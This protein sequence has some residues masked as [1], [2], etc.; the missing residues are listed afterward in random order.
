[1]FRRTVHVLQYSIHVQ[2][3]SSSEEPFVTCVRS[4]AGCYFNEGRTVDL[5]VQINRKTNKLC[6]MQSP[7]HST[8]VSSSSSQLI[9]HGLLIHTWLILLFSI[10][11]K[12]L[13]NKNV[14][15]NEINYKMLN[16]IDNMNFFYMF[17]AT[18][19]K[20]CQMNYN[21]HNAHTCTNQQKNK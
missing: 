21:K 13:L 20:L 11:K 5:S 12:I 9:W 10:N 6:N 8:Q 4:A 7:P 15:I 17:N 16:V 14:K 18:S 3:S 2:D 19:V 1:M